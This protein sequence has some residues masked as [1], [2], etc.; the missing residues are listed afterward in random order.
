MGMQSKNSLFRLRNS[1]TDPHK[2]WPKEVET[3]ACQF[4]ALTSRILIIWK[5]CQNSEIPRN[6]TPTYKC[7]KLASKELFEP[8]TV[9][10]CAS[11]PTEEVYICCFLVGNTQKRS[12][13]QVYA[14]LI[15]KLPKQ[16]F[17]EDAYQE[18][19]MIHFVRNTGIC[20]NFFTLTFFCYRWSMFWNSDTV[21]DSTILKN[22]RV[23]LSESVAIIFNLQEINNS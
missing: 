4:D 22:K 20:W 21:W 17:Y 12:K 16:L 9:R 5:K 10:F 15:A 6:L 19:N 8:G 7:S 2:A 14:L 18:I 1:H 3:N 13:I 23:F 11:D